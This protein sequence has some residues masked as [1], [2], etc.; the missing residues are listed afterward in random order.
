MHT[1]M[2]KSNGYG[3]IH[4]QIVDI[5]K[6]IE[7]QIGGGGASLNVN[8]VTAGSIFIG[9]N[10]ITTVAG[11]VININAKLNFKGGVVGLPVAYNYFLR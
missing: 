6:Y 11:Q 8:S 3:W 5:G 2:V 10:T 9:T 4:K 7:A 1:G